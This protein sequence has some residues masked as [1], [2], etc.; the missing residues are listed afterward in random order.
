M[1]DEIDEAIATYTHEL[2]AE[3]SLAKG[4]VAEI[5]D[6]LRS[7]IDELRAHQ[8][9]GVA[10]AQAKLR[11]GEPRALAREHARVSGSFGPPLSR[12]RA[13]SAV[14]LLVPMLWSAF[15]TMRFEMTV[16]NL[17]VASALAL[18]LGLLAGRGWARPVMFAGA[19]FWLLPMALSLY[20][21]PSIS[22]TWL[23]LHAGIVAF[24][25]P[26]RRREITYAGVALALQTW[27]ATSAIMV[28]GFQVTTT[29]NGPPEYVTPA[30]LVAVV[31][32]SKAT[33][34]GILRARWSAIASLVSAVTLAVSIHQLVGMSFKFAHGDL[35]EVMT[36]AMLAT[37][38]LASL[39]AS[40]LLWRHARSTFGSLR[41]VFA[42]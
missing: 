9:L 18:G 30:A 29:M 38:A 15:A 25:A 23:V 16:Q 42:S 26:W 14:A 7:L 24:L 6:H 21:D 8:P 28:L 2:Q 40:V 35:Y 39:A 22:P 19:A 41:E 10:I 37:G 36:F 33:V 31:A 17:E 32:A 13:V 27:A 4:D 3:A 20:C 11:L 12:W 1:R 34:G 5:E